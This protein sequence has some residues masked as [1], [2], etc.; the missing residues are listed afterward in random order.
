MMGVA[1]D[2][3]HSGMNRKRGLGALALSY[4]LRASKGNR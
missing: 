2:H 1:Q 3:E 4:C